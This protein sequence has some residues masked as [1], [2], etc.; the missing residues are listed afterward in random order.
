MISISTVAVATSFPR[1]G[2]H[3]TVACAFVGSHTIAQPPDTEGNLFFCACETTQRGQISTA[4]IGV[5]VRNEGL[6]QQTSRF[7]QEFTGKNEHFSC[8]IKID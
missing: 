2:L 1:D 8:N 5:S 4:Q 6:N 7:N 3:P